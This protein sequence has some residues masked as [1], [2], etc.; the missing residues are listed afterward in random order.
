MPRCCSA[1]SSECGASLE[2]WARASGPHDVLLAAPARSAPGSSG[3]SRSSS[4]PWSGSA[5]PVFVR[6]QIVHNAHVVA[7]LEAKG[8]V[9]VAELDEVPD[10]ATVVL[11]AHGVSPAVRAA[12]A[13]RRDLTVIDATCPLVA[14]VHHEARRFVAQD[15]QIVLV[16][17]ADHEE[18]VGTM[19][20]A[21]DRI[22]L[23][24]RPRG[25][26]GTSRST[27]TPGGLPDPDDAGRPTRRPRSSTPC[28]SASPTGGPD[29][30]RHLLRHPEPPGRGARPGRASATCC[31]W[32]ARPT[33][34]TPPAWSR[35]PG[36]EGCRAELVEDASEISTRVGSTALATDRAHGGRLGTRVTRDRGHRHAA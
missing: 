3:P 23:V 31:S 30:Q 13:E 22:Q 19:G 24:Q 16:G 32:S 5:A 11:A 7:D 28:A 14:K 26:G 17:H 12:A 29:V 1:P 4:A 18:V 36:G 15:Y 10:G 34:P 8:A 21:P 35:S 20:E 27:S 6:R 25:R 9:F 2:R 33:R